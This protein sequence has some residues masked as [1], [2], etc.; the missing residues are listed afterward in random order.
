MNYLV[1]NISDDPTIKEFLIAIPS[2]Q[3]RD[4]IVFTALKIGVNTIQKIPA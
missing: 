3:K 4:K 2:N 1:V